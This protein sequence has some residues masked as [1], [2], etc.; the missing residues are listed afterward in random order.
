[1]IRVAQVLNHMNSGGVEAVVMNYYRNIDRTKVQFDFIVSGDSTI[2]QRKE[3]ESLGGR[4][5]VLPKIKQFFAYRK[6]L[7]KILKENNYKIVHAHMSTLAYFPLSVAK[8]CNVPVRIC[9]NHSTSSPKEFVRNVAKKLLKPLAKKYATDFYACGELAGRWMY[10]DKAFDGGKVTVMNNAID[11]DKFDFNQKV[12]EEV[13]KEL[14]IENNF[15]VG[16]IGRFDD[17][18]NHTFLIDIFA[19]LLKKDVSAVLVLA[20]EGPLQEQAKQKAKELGIEDR[21]KFLGVRRDANR[22]YQAFDVFV[23]PSLYE[24]LPVV[25]VEAQTSGLPCVVSDKVSAAVKMTD[26][27]QFE[28][29]DKSAGEWADLVLKTKDLVRESQKE[30]ISAAGYDIKAEAKKLEKFYLER[31]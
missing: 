12:R 15:V 3:I 24:G 19:E 25:M 8:K 2:P 16:H 4:V 9:H 14:A 17:Q 18:K 28:S 30:K 29:L 13:R 21:V 20:G 11:L 26:N 5:F 23:L 27:L 31:K 7:S 22:L 6:E 10:G 1:M